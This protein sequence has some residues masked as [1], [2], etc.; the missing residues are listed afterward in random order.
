MLAYA[1]LI[2]GVYW[3]FGAAP[4]PAILG[5]LTEAVQVLQPIVSKLGPLL[6]TYAIL[7]FVLNWFGSDLLRL[8]LSNEIISHRG[9][10]RVVRKGTFLTLLGTLSTIARRNYLETLPSVKSLALLPSI[11]EAWDQSPSGSPQWRAP[12]V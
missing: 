8:V 12:P 2:G 6:I 7:Y 11:S 5:F 1:F 3:L 9:T 4:I 10:D